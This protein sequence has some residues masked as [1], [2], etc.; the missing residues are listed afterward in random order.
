[1]PPD[2]SPEFTGRLVSEM[3]LHST[4]P[5][6]FAIAWRA[7]MGYFLSLELGERKEN[8]PMLTDTQKQLTALRTR[9]DQARNYL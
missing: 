3:P 2:A 9:I 6:L 1:M 7:E 4:F 5:S 8:T